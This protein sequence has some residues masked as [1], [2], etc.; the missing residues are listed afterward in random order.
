M[1][2]V[3][4]KPI[5]HRGIECI[6]IFSARNNALNNWLQKKVNAK[7]SRTH[8]CW[9]IPC[10]QQSYGTLLSALKGKVLFETKAAGR[11]VVV[12]AMAGIQHHGGDRVQALDFLGAQ[13]RLDRFRQIQP[14]D[15]QLAVLQMGRKGEPLLHPIDRWA[16]RL[17]RRRQPKGDCPVRFRL[18][19]HIRSHRR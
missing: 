10:T 4:L 1:E 3:T 11:A 13:P 8:T 7:W 5:F 9:H 17:P 2:I 12:A 19:R 15:E 18:R 6:G 16:T 14:R